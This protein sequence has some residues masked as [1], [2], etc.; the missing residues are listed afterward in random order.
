MQDQTANFL[1]VGFHN[2]YA[3]F[4]A[5]PGLERLLLI[6]CISVIFILEKVHTPPFIL[7][8]DSKKEI[9]SAPTNGS[10][11]NEAKATETTYKRVK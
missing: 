11:G 6:L 5:F 2:S 10:A 3:F 9:S 1:I 4:S 7:R 8:S